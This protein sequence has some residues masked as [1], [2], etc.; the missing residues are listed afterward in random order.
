MS[1]ICQSFWLTFSSS[2]LSN[3]KQKFCFRSKKKTCWNKY[4][5]W[6]EKIVF[7]FFYPRGAHHFYR[8]NSHL[9]LC[10]KPLTIT[11]GNFVEIKQHLLK[12]RSVKAM[13]GIHWTLWET[14]QWPLISF[15]EC[16]QKRNFS[17]FRQRQRLL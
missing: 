17:T 4:M 9:N 7:H 14:I 5:F 12:I 8:L 6:W 11:P 15:F 3:I 1:F 16:S 10:F 2:V 13:Q